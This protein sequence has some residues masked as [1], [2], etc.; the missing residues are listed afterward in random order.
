S[1]LWKQ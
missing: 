1:R